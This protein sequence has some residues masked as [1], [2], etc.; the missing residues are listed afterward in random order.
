M[1]K[2]ILTQEPKDCCGCRACEQMCAHH[3]LQMKEDEEGFLYPVL[4][5]NLCVECGLCDKVCPMA[6]YQK[7]LHKEGM[8]IAAQNLNNE[9]LATSSS[10]GGFIA[11]AKSII[12]DGGVVYGAAFDKGATLCHQRVTDYSDLEYL[13]GSKYLQSDT[14]GA[15]LLVKNDLDSGRKVYF[16]GTPCQV[17]GL[18]LYLRKEYDLLFT[19]D[20]VCHGTP[21]NKIFKNTITQIEQRTNTKFKN[22]SFRDKNVRGWSCSS[23][24]SW[25]KDGKEIHKIYSKDMEAY[26]NAFIQGDLMRMN[27]YSCPFARFERCGDITLADYWG[28]RQYNPDFPSIGKGVSLFIINSEKGH[29]K[30]G[31]IKSLFYWQDISKEHATR[32]RN[33][34]EPTPLTA[35]RTFSYRL[36][37]T[38]YGKFV[39]KYY[40]G[41]YT[42]NSLKIHFEYFI[43]RSSFLFTLASFL[44]RTVK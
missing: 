43:R 6:H 10:G 2:Y 23:S 28:V 17:A 21:S 5:P 19:S 12:A 33:L 32:N 14:K 8:P 42:A 7:V 39:R 3:A 29:E 27:C 22:Y 16:V 37:F 34:H 1:I 44:K 41:N 26:F 36:A 24:S 31:N 18:R 25:E 9:D 11:I 30:F 35:N 4:T 20:F 38:D 15:Y 13:K 40:K